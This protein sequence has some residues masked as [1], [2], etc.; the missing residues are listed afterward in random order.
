MDIEPVM[1]KYSVEVSSISGSERLESGCR[2]S[3]AKKKVKDIEKKDSLMYTVKEVTMPA[4]NGRNIK[5]PQQQG[6]TIVV[7]GGGSFRRE[8]TLLKTKLGTK[9]CRQVEL[10][11]GA[12]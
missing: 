1:E 3:V 5:K 6:K 8:Q 10:P 9:W 2:P 11:E 12:R 7:W 4:T